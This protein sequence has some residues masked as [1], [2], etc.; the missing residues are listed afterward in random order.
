MTQTLPRLRE[1]YLR[2][3]LAT[4]PVSLDSNWSLLSNRVGIVQVSVLI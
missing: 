1:S 2:T 3:S 4:E